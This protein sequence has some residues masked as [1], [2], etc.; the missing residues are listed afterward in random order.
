MTLKA[1]LPITHGKI[2]IYKGVDD[3]PDTDYVDLYVGNAK[4]APQELSNR[5]IHIVA[6]YD[7]GILEV[8]IK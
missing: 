5:K 8:Q 2:A 4:K 7:R 3:T 1:I 6:V